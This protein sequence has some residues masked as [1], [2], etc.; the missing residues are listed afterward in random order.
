MRT[1]RVLLIVALVAGTLVAVPIALVA[2]LGWL[3]THLPDVPS[4]EPV[5]PPLASLS[6]TRDGG[7]VTEI[8][9]RLAPGYLL[10]A[11][12]NLSLFDGFEPY[13]KPEVTQR[14]LGPPTGIWRVPP[15]RAPPLDKRLDIDAP[16]Y[17]RPDGRVT[18]R[19]FPTPEQG[20]NWVP[21]AYPK[22]CTLEY[23]FPDERLRLQIARYLSP[24]A[25]TSLQ[26]R[27][28]DGLNALLVSLD[29]RGCRDVELESRER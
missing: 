17:D 21:V 24:D 2:L 19:P 5:T 18:L 12:V 13:V 10:D 9:A 23:L 26:V 3:I 27:K 20:P 11:S 16:Y 28:S 6:V 29:S 25:L 14:R 22:N 1:S 7:R 8:L 15:R 4:D